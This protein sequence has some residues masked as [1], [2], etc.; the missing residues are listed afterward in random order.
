MKQTYSIIVLINCNEKLNSFKII[1]K[2]EDL[3]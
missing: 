2:K 1:T 3:T